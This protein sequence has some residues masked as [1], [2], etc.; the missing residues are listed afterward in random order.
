MK[1]ILTAVPV[2]LLMTTMARGQ[3][4]EP[5]P[6][7]DR[8]ESEVRL[9]AILL[10]NLFQAPE[11]EPQEDVSGG[12]LELRGAWDLAAGGLATLYGRLGHTEY[13][14]GLDA[15]QNLG[16]GLRGE[17]GIHGWNLLGE[18]FN[19]RPSVEADVF[20]QADVTRVTAAYQVRPVPSWQFGLEGVVEQQSYAAAVDRDN[21]FSSLGA[22]VRYR[23]FGRAFSP[24]IGYS[25]GSRDVDND[26]SSH[27]QDE[28][29]ARVISAPTE[30]L[31]L[32]LRWRLRQREY[33]TGD[34]TASNFGR[35]DDRTQW[36]F[37]GAWRSGP[38]LSW[39]LYLARE[40]SESTRP[41]VDFDTTIA[42]FGIGYRLD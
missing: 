25:V 15:S 38:R 21:D 33:T 31:H 29:F 9:D 4:V 28:L 22:A 39:N 8:F 3:E 30:D 37:T 13:D 2:L 18:Y 40:E 6:G 34:A 12:R 20:D 7:E 1:S 11:G 36:A 16:L 19:D 42:T 35:E 24:E 23:G 26:V 5:G 41:G 17:S 32:A 10:D 14:S 27:D